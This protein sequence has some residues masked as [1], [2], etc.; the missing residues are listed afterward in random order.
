MIKKEGRKIEKQDRL[1]ALDVFRGMT[2]A[3][4][5]IVNIPGSWSY[6]YAPLRHAKWH[7]CTPTDLV[8]PFFLFAVG[9]AMSYSFRKYDHRFSAA[10]LKKIARRAALIFLIGLFLNVFPFN[11]A[12]SQ[13][14]ILGVL[15]R[16][17]I[18]YGLAALLY[19]C[20]NQTKLIFATGIILIGY[21]LLMLGFGRGDP[22]G[23][24]TNLVRII[25][26]K[27]I[28]ENHMWKG[29][30]IPFD[31]EGLLSTLPSIA[32]VTLGALTGRLIQSAAN[33]KSAIYK[34]LL[35][36]GLFILLGRI[37]NITFPI[38]KY[39]WTSSYVLY[40]AGLAMICIAVFLWLIDVKG[41]KRWAFPFVV[42]GM[43]SLFLYA[44]SSIW[45]RIYIYFIKITA[46]DGT[47]INGYKWL[48]ENIF[49]PIAGNLNGSLLF[50]ITHVFLF[51]VI[52]YLLY[53]KRIFIKI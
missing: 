40:T 6:V 1:I 32:T 38:N 16:I 19:L 50:A 52:L 2:I 4:M 45:V 26:L 34:I 22:Y 48:Y 9:I 12:I 15:Q 25:D 42:F 21:W 27:I 47:V 11:K 51:W 44:L 10:A 5:I 7:G 33:L 23:V 37:W 20:L 29:V 39:L 17:G 24:E 41:I 13:I 31:P 36:A 53:R 3:L 28:G 8:F 14:R 49:V 18:A 35:L 30:G 43:N 46:P